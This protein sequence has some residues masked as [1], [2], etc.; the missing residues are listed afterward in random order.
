M[1][2]YLWFIKLHVENWYKYSNVKINRQEEDVS[3]HAQA[4]PASDRHPQL[5]RYRL[6]G[7]RAQKKGL[8][9]NVYTRSQ[10]ALNISPL[11]TLHL[12]LCIQS[13]L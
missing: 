13:V 6:Q 11:G 10:C 2:I 7:Y 5:I 4:F 8:F 3:G 9:E 12:I 1:E